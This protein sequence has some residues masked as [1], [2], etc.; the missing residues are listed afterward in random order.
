METEIILS[1]R[2]KKIIDFYKN[3]PSLDFEQ[4]NLLCVDLFENILQ[5]A[6]NA[7]NKSISSQILSEC[8]DNKSML[9]EL[10]TQL[11]FLQ[12]SVSNISNE[13]IIKFLDIKKD[14]V[15]EVKN[16]FNSNTNDK[17]DKLLLMIEKNNTNLLDKTINIFNDNNNKSLEKTSSLI[18]KSTLQLIDKTNLLL[19]ELIPEIH[20]NSNKDII[21]EINKFQLSINDEL[22]QLYNNEKNIDNQIIDFLNKT[23]EHDKIIS[24]LNFFL[25]KNKEIQIENF[26]TNIE[27]KFSTL[28]QSFMNDTQQQRNKHDKVFG[29]LEEYLNKYRN[30]SFKG[31]LCENR[32]RSILNKL[33]PTAEVIDTSG[34][35]ESGDCI[36]KRDGKDSILFETKEYDTNVNPDEVKKF[37][38]DCDIQKCHG[39]FLSQISGITTKNNYHIDYHKGF[40]L[41]YVHYAEYMPS[42]IQVAIDIIDSI[43]SKFKELS[44]TSDETNDSISKEIL[45]DI[46]DEYQRFITQKINL[47]NI[48]KDFEKKIM[49]Q[50]NDIKIPT[51]ENYLSKKYA[52]TQKTQTCDICK[53]FTTE[54]TRS[55][56]AHKRHCKSNNI[57]IET[58]P[59]TPNTSQTPL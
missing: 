15:E 10:N 6:A 45:D 18:D 4:V 56:A 50:L 30:S 49:S 17:Y 8:N 43:S 59:A 1:T 48:V 35:K 32:L 36:L 14:Y 22:K 55:L 38:R 23:S 57:I 27:I 37:I 9:K 33:N 2:N 52:T 51:L 40:F 39:I 12:K 21:N 13:V 58:Q 7:M 54:T 20:N 24:E 29:D 5:D 19:R 26:V 41:V 11:S 25:N 46:N 34:I 44:F 31:Q 53:V 3:N 47:Q 42:K 28:L 16:I